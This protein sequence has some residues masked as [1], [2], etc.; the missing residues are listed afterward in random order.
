MIPHV[1][2]DLGLHIAI[3]CMWLFAILELMAHQA[4]AAPSFKDAIV[5]LKQTYSNPNIDVEDPNS[6]L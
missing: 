1:V 3:A 4:L 5:C 6:N 2:V